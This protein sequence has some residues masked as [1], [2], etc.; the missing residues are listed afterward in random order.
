MKKGK[1]QG[2]WPG[3]RAL[4][5]GPGALTGEA[6]VGNVGPWGYSSCVIGIGTRSW[7]VED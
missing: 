3:L 2:Q 4:S 7:H 6:G 1:L 5:G